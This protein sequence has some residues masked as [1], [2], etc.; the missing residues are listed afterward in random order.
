MMSKVTEEIEIECEMDNYLVQ[1]Q[2]PPQNM[3]YIC[4][5]EESVVALYT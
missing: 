5:V 1:T 2:N 3:N 4:M